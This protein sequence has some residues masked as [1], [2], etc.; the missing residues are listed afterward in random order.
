MLE[1]T[2]LETKVCRRPLISL[3]AAF[4]LL[5]SVW[6]TLTPLFAGPD[7]PASY[8]RGAAI[9]RGVIVGTNIP[10]SES[11]AYWS[12]YVDIPQ[13]FGVAQLV[14]WCFVGQ[15]E[16]PACSQ[17]L[18]TLVPVEDP[19]TDMG[20]YPPTGYF[21]S[22]LG[23]LL[24]PNDLSV[25]ISRIINALV[26]AFL[27][28]LACINLLKAKRSLLTLIVAVS[29]G[30]IFFSSII[31][32]SAIE[33]SAALCFWC[34]L[35]VDKTKE[36][37]LN[38]FS[39]AVSGSL[40]VLAR[41]TGPIYFVIALV[42]IWIANYSD[43][44][45]NELKLRFLKPLIAPVISLLIAIIW[46]L[47][48]YSFNLKNSYAKKSELPTLVEVVEQSFGDLSRKISEAVGNFGWLDTPAPT[49]A[50]WFFFSATIFVIFSRWEQRPAAEKSASLTLILL[51]FVMM[52]YL[53]WNTQKYGGK[54]G[55]QGRHL[56]PLLVGVPIIGG[57]NW[58]P[59][60]TAKK[61][62]LFGWTVSLFASGVSA[63][64]RYTVGVK[65]LNF[66]K[67]F[68]DPIWVPR[69][70]V[71]PTLISLFIVSSGVAIIVWIIESAND[72]APV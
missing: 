54:F 29:P 14:P 18:E 58:H 17:P 70:G 2:G 4:F 33:I 52:V 35:S 48:I 69:F 1:S 56:T 46:H 62:L 41:T 31:N 38:A 32:S 42:V 6:S 25:L 21:F 23:S 71:T 65:D 27:I 9:V 59:S 5:I 47:R 39:I 15:P 36:S 40:L 68:S 64:R 55:V 19:R 44:S 7:E 63:L 10:A 13:Q 24:G 3:T 37:K 67:M 28:S 12:T 22:G 11:T 49:F 26:C 8:I 53:N 50:V 20:R 34:G 57:A 51:V 72:R 66:F 43:K 16:K 61:L 60:K 30:V 45:L